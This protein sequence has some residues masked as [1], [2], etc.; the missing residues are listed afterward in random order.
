MPG[1]ISDNYDPEFSTGANAAEV[2]AGVQEMR[3]ALSVSLSEDLLPILDVVRGENDMRA[4]L[5]YSFSV[6]ELR[7]IRFAMNRAIESI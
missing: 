1:P 6:R 2:R 3:D 7:I 5:P 4:L